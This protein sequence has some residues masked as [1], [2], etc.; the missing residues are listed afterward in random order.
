MDFIY[1]FTSCYAVLGEFEKLGK[2]TISFVMSVLLSI[3]LSAGT[4]LLPQH[5]FSW[6]SIL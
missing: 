1:L 2:A 5:R 3:R 4:T 6:N